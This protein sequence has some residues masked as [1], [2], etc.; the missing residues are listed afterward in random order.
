MDIS[1]KQAALDIAKVNTVPIVSTAA[2]SSS[3]VSASDVLVYLNIAL[4]AVG[5]GYALY[6]WYVLW[7]WR[8]RVGTDKSPPTITE[9]LSEN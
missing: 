5:L 6:K 4:A 1:T 7:S 8:R 9:T 3:A 2:A